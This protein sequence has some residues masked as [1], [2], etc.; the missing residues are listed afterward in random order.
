MLAL[1]AWILLGKLLDLVLNCGP[2]LHSQGLHR[3]MCMKRENRILRD[4]FGFTFI[5]LLVV[6]IMV[7]ILASISIPG[8]SAWLPSYRLRVAAKDLYSNLQLAK[9]TAIKQNTTSAVI[10]DTGASPGKYFICSDPGANG[11]WDGP[12]AMGG[13]DTS[14]K[15]VELS[16]YGSGVDYGA[17]NATDDIPGGGTPPADVITYTTPADVAL[18]SP[19]GTVINPGASGSYAY[20]S[21][22]RGSTYGV[23]T[24]SIAGVVI[25]RKWNENAWE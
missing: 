1:V 9:L 25:L 24:P 2:F 12:A 6:M 3:E 17:G 14:I 19:S 13:D 20:L 22:D 23:G 8:F 7:A 15:T 10:F 11:N 5:E 18:F 21:N 16:K 4:A